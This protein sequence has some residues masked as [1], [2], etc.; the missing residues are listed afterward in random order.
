[1]TRP[2]LAVIGA[3]LAGAKAV[4]AARDAGYDGRIVLIGDEPGTPYERPPLSKAVLRGEAEPDSTR[5]HPDGFY[6]DH[7]IELVTDQVAAIDT[8]TRRVELA[9]G[10]T[11]PFDTAILATGAEPRRLTMPGA[12]LDG[13]R[14]LRSVDDAVRLRDS[15]HASSRVAV[16]GAGWIGSEVAASARQMGADVVLTAPAPVPLQRVL[17]DQVGDVFRKLHAD[18]GVHLRLGLGVQ[19]LRGVGAVEEVVLADGTTEAADLVVVGIGVTPRTDVAAGTGLLIDDGI[20]VD[21]HLES[22]V[23][24]IYAAGDVANAW[25]PYYRR[26]VRVEHWAN[27]LNQGTTA[28]RNVAG[29]R[30][31]YDRLPYFFSDQ[32]DLGME[33]VGLGDPSDALVVRGDLDA[34][35]FVA[36]WHREGVVTAAMNVNVWDVVDDLKTIVAAGRPAD[37]DRLADRSVALGEVVGASSG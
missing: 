14:Y 32:Y 8:V 11:L 24:G 20:V 21:E 18:N 12:E 25:H 30:G 19:E 33:Y 37:L 31:V 7:D 5:V 28:G 1:M 34:R 6:G 29:Q 15:I 16:I 26:H 4:E 17:G 9:D 13:V 23:A 2:T 3:S 36:F 22:G 35:E 10:D 27:A